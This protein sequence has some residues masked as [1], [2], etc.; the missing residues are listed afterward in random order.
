MADLTIQ[1]RTLT[2]LEATFAAAATG[3]DSFTNTGVETFRVKNGH[4][5]DITVTVAAQ[6]ACSHGSLHN[7]VTVI[8]AGEERDI[9]PFP[10]D[11]FNDLNGKCQATY[12]LIT[13][14]TVAVIQ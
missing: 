8:T 2:G 13:A 1:R 12:S 14:L 10:V 7:S 11:R 3:G 6:K 9:G 5:A 4:S